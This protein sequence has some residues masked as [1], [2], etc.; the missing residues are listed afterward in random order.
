MSS[1]FIII[2]PGYKL[3]S[4]GT[5]EDLIKDLEDHGKNVPDKTMKE[6]QR[7]FRKRIIVTY[8]DTDFFLALFKPLDRLKENT[9]KIMKEEEDK[10][11]TR[12]TCI[13][14][15]LLA[16]RYGHDP[17]RIVIDAMEICR[18]KNSVYGAAAELISRCVGAFDSFHEVHSNGKL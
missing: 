12:A 1:K 18:E 9:M 10:I 7:K 3:I 17:V 14:L 11:Y 2:C 5:P 4:A 15:M 6:L 8:A 13:E 16:K